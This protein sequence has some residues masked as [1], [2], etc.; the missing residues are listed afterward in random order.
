MCVALEEDLEEDDLDLLE[1]NTG[2]R[3][4]RKT[5]LTR[6]RRG[7][8]SE[9]P[10]EPRAKRPFKSVL[11][12]QLSEDE[13]DLDV[14][15]PVADVRGIWDDDRAGGR[16]LDDDVDMDDDFIDDDLDDDGMG[17][18]GEEE[19]E[20][21]RKERQRQER[22]RKKAMGRP[23]MVGIDAACVFFF[24]LAYTSFTFFNAS[25]QCLG[26]NIRRVW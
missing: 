14:E 19:R 6:L 24:F 15:P 3:I 13:D 7:R 18:L 12:D 23:D 22:E 26:R 4:A 2:T 16:D 17:D 10:A 21:R 5:K 9:S 8:D 25:F 1:E 11:D 20:E